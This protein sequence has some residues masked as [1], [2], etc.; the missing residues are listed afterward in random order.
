MNEPDWEEYQWR[1]AHT[2]LAELVV[3]Y[4]SI[5]RLEAAEV[6]ADMADDIERVKDIDE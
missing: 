1:I 6:A 4:H 3:S 5:G 2:A